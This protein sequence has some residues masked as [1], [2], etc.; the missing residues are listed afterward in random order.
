MTMTDWYRHVEACKACTPFSPCANGA[1]ILERACNDTAARL[2]GME[3]I[4]IDGHKLA[5]LECNG[6]R[7]CD[8][9]RRINARAR[10]VVLDTNR[11]LVPA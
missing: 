2:C 10:A 9:A 7:I 5:C 11:K 4:D 8:E 1:V 6:T 3:I